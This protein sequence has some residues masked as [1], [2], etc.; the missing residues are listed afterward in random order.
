MMPA[1]STTTT[2]AMVF[3]KTSVPAMYH[4]CSTAATQSHATRHQ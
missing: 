1:T 2:A 3:A 4:T